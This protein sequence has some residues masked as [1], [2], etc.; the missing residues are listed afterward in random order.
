MGFIKGA[1]VMGRI[2]TT[3]IHQCQSIMRLLPLYTNVQ[4]VPS[5][6]PDL[7]ARISRWYHPIL[8]SLAVASATH[9]PW[10]G[11][12]NRI[13]LRVPAYIPSS[14]PNSSH[15]VSAYLFCV[16]LFRLKVETTYSNVITVRKPTGVKVSRQS[17]DR[18]PPLYQRTKSPKLGLD[19]FWANVR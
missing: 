3:D 4:I 8:H 7:R 13:R 18:T 19:Q 14:N 16:S 17:S 12:E 2:N 6:I 5:W 15:K 9:T 10:T 1:S 11:L